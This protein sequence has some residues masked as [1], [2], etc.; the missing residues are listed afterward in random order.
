MSLFRA[1]WARRACCALFVAAPLAVANPIPQRTAR[2]IERRHYVGTTPVTGSVVLNNG[3]TKKEGYL[4]FAV[5]NLRVRDTAMEFPHTRFGRVT[6][7]TLQLTVSPAS[8]QTIT[9]WAA[10]NFSGSFG[11]PAK[12]GTALA[13]AQTASATVSF[14]VKDYISGEG[15]FS[16]RLST[17]GTADVTITDA[18]LVVDSND[19]QANLAAVTY[20]PSRY[21]DLG[22]DY[23]AR[24]SD[25]TELKNQGIINVA[26]QP[27]NA[28]PDDGIDDTLALQRA[29]NEAQAARKVVFLPGG[30]YNISDTISMDTP[31]VPDQYI[32]PGETSLAAD[33]EYWSDQ[34]FP[35]IMRGARTGVE[36]RLTPKDASFGDTTKPKPALYMW[37]R[38]D[39]LSGDG[40]L[41]RHVANFNHTLMHVKVNVGDAAAGAAN[42]AG[43][44]GV[45]LPGSQGVRLSDVEVIATGAFAGL[46][47]LPGAGG[48]THG[49]KVTGGRY[50]A[51]VKQVDYSESLHGYTSF[52]NF[53]TFIDQTEH[54]V[55][56][57]GAGYVT[58]VGSR[59]INNKGVYLT[60]PAGNPWSAQLC[61]VDSH[62]KLNGSATAAVSGRR[63]VYL[64]NVYVDGTAAASARIVHVSANDTSDFCSL[65]FS[66]ST[67]SNKIGNF[68]GSV[69]ID[70]APYDAAGVTNA[71]RVPIFLDGGVH[72]S[73]QWTTGITNESAPPENDP[74]F[75]KHD[76]DDTPD[77]RNTAGYFN[78]V[79]VATDPL[80]PNDVFDDT[81]KLQD[82]IT[83]HPVVFLPPGTYYITRKLVLRPDS[84]IFGV[85]KNYTIIKPMWG[86]FRSELEPLV[87]TTVGAADAPMLADLTLRTR[88]ANESDDKAYQLHWRSGKGTVKDLLFDRH[89]TS[90]KDAA[91]QTHP[92]TVIRGGGKWYN[93]WINR[94]FADVGY[95]H[96]KID[97]STA[98][99]RMYVCNPEYARVHPQVEIVNSSNFDLF[100]TKSEGNYRNY[101]FDNCSNFRV[102]GMGGNSSPVS[103]E[104]DPVNNQ[105]ILVQGCSNF[106]FAAQAY[107]QRQPSYQNKDDAAYNA[108][109]GARTD[110]ATYDRLVE[111]TAG[112]GAVIKATPGVQ[113]FIVYRR[114]TP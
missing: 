34:D 69:V 64:R 97:G 56:Y 11:L 109:G 16:F 66:G 111:K 54:G 81:A 27:Y 10:N 102:Y 9:V 7:A 55:Y 99:L 103:G 94:D 60:A 40:H 86:T 21:R 33:G 46:G 32:D 112:G 29:V 61:M 25:Q 84:K 24:Y 50:G 73:N 51:Y 90:N 89:M 108:V 70:Q 31:I 82:A 63:S 30:V 48:I 45:S 88:I 6:G 8:G 42:N 92:M 110:P 106:L 3:T 20:T 38:D 71:S 77:F 65:P 44:I 95:R 41:N 78:P 100:A 52:L 5:E 17:N 36:I 75:T 37:S 98:G 12:V 13:P 14:D 23:I 114:G 28:I 58:I 68:A 2:V 87:E 72:N 96:L 113:Q 26:K 4:S 101:T 15:V 107:Q 22:K 62:I 74:F 80:N 57:D 105:N 91:K 104:K 93:F 43:A 19:G 79:A 49:V 67:R 47:G 59:F 39:R 85:G 53:C 18:D 35:T 1:R 76:W 83:N